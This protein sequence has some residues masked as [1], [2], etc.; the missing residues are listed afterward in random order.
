[1]PCSVLPHPWLTLGQVRCKHLGVLL[2][3]AH[4][5]VQVLVQHLLLALLYLHRHLGAHHAP[6]L[7]PEPGHLGGGREGWKGCSCHGT[8][9][10]A[11]HAFMR[12]QAAQLG[13]TLPGAN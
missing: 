2:S 6:S 12:V 1:M 5:E 13:W 9:H 10:C 8:A 3:L 11:H 7:G 4:N